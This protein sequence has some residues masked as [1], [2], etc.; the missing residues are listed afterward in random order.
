[1]WARVIGGLLALAIAVAVM[2]P[3]GQAH[4]PAQILRLAIAD[5]PQTLDPALS[6]LPGE[7]TIGRQVTVTLLAPTPDL[8]DV[9]PLAA[10]DYA[11]SPDGMTYT[12]H[13]RDSLAYGDGR[14][15]VARDY[16]FAWA[17]LLDPRVGSPWAGLFGSAV[18][19]GKDLIQL[20][21]KTEADK[22]P[23]AISA[24]GL[25]AP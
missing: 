24:L 25:S 18:K 3:L 4:P 9:R 22:I 2:V 5:Q 21:P 14:A 20:D 17:R 10:Q 6:R 11:V 16:V 13:L 1:M 23:T 19:G 7:A 15:V 12:F 8:K